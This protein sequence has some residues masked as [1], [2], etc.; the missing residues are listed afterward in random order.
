MWTSFEALCDLGV[1]DKT[2]DPTSVFGVQPQSLEIEAANG[3]DHETLGR[4]VL[5]PSFA[6]LQTPRDGPRSALRTP[7]ATGGSMPKAMLFHS[8]AGGVNNSV[9][10]GSDSVHHQ[11]LKSDAIGGNG[12]SGG[13][14]LFQT[15]NLTPIAKERSYFVAGQNIPASAVPQTTNTMPR[16]LRRAQQVASRQYYEP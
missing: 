2:L 10:G 6:F 7:P 11:P 14:S 13:Q 5:T 16:V 3:S 12:T 1:C 9:V 15:P 8:G 4:G